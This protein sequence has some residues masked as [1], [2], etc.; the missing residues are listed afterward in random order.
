M[1]HWTFNICM[2]K[3]QTETLAFAYKCKHTR[4]N[5]LWHE[6]QKSHTRFLCPS[7]FHALLFIKDLNH[8]LM[9][10]E[11]FLVL[12]QHLLICAVCSYLWPFYLEPCQS[13]CR[14]HSFQHHR[15]KWRQKLV[16]TSE[17]RADL[18]EWALQYVV[19]ETKTKS[20]FLCC[21]S[22]ALFA[23]ASSFSMHN[24]SVKDDCGLVFLFLAK[25][26]SICKK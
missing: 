16:I 13:G 21:V 19:A 9:H 17:K 5:V 4:R 18:S 25:L 12:W 23:V 22:A 8:P 3:S 1:Q 24:N 14:F 20:S 11:T 2:W 10:D 7:R 26:N 15:C 6:P